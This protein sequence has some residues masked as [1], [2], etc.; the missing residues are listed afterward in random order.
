MNIIPYQADHLEKLMLQPSQAGVRKYFGNPEYG[1]ML[2]LPGLAF[3]ATDGD[4][5]LAM[6]GV[7][8]RW[9]GR[10]EAWALLAG[11]LTRHFVQIHRAVLRFLDATDIRRIET[12][13]DANFPAGLAWVELLGFKNEGL[14]PGYTP[15]GRDCYRFA[16]VKGR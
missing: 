14:M 8:P 15:E 3:T 16:R 10:A 9:E 2:E 7:L 4:A 12:A 11:D 1:K 13:V 6:A 5:V